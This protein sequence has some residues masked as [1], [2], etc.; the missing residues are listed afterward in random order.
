MYVHFN[1][2][3]CGKSVGDCVIRALCKV[4]NKSWYRVYLELCVQGFMD[5]NWGSSN[6]VWGNYLRSKGFTKALLP[7]SC[8]DCYTVADFAADNPV[9]AFILG[10]GEHVVAVVNGDYYD[11]WDSGREIPIYVYLKGDRHGRTI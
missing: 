8:P 2:N 10:T 9:G 7:D 11:S 6:S 1:P 4:F 5:C 3:P